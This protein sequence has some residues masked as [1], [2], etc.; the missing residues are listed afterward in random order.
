MT[1]IEEA[2]IILKDL[3]LPKLQQNEMSAL[4]LLAL[5]DISE[6][7]NW[8][9]AKKIS[10]GV[11]K[12]IMKFFS[13]VYNK[14]YAP[15]TRETVRRFVLH[16]FEQARV[17]DYNPD[18]PNLP[19][20]SPRAHYAV[21]KEALKVIQTFGTKDW[22]E[23]AKNFRDSIANLAEEYA[24]KR[25]VVRVPVKLPNGD[26]LSLSSGKHNE[27]Q[28]AIVEQFRPEFAKNSEL[29]YLGDTEQK[30]L[31]SDNKTMSE[32]GI[33]IDQHSKLPDV[34]LYDKDK[35]W[36]YLIEA[37]TSHGPVSPKR[38]VEL[39]QLLEDCDAGLI[40]V[41]AFPD[42]KEFKKWSNQIAWETEIWICEMPSHM[43]HFNGDRFMGPR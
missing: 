10:L 17:A 13:D 22:D 4:T 1:K 8:K 31:Y 6:K 2:Q 19:V 21:S 27:V 3:G 24:K 28:A 7:D 5:C 33:P 20:N 23:N 36:L 34:V 15:N 42:F 35:N 16:Q 9:A 39:K 26:T 32:I 14:D 29:L 30:G 18:I 12:G 37:V 38:I 25:T 43:I 41:T 11:T 40:Y